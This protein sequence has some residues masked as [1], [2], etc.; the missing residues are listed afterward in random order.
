VVEA[1]GGQVRILPYL[2]DRSTSSIIERVRA[3]RDAAVLGRL[4]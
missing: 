4:A 1:Q 2:R 3:S